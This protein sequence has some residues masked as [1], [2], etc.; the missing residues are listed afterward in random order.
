M[1]GDADLE[2]SLHRRD[3]DSY[4]AGLRFSQADTDA[5][6]RLLAGGAASVRVDFD[7]LRALALDEIAYGRAL[8]AALLADDSLRTAFA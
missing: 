6:I 2:L 7:Q 1:P 5:D 4:T 8:G 3:A